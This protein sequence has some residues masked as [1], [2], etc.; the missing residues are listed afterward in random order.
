MAEQFK[1]I[2]SEALAQLCVQVAEA[3]KGEN[4][5]ALKI[6][7]VSVV[8]DYFVICTGTSTPHVGALAEWIRRK[9]R[10]QTDRRP[11]VI[12]GTAESQ[13]M[14]ID[15]GDVVVHVLSQE[16]RDRYQLEELWSDAPR[17]EKAIV[18]NSPKAEA[19]DE[20]P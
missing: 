19:A 17:L 14:V 12:A 8:A 16:A 7:V 15:F 6:S 13:W 5:V 4:I 1:E 11:R 20:R 9:V 3:R 10:E 18:E 2:D